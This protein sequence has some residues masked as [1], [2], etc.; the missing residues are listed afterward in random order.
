MFNVITLRLLQKASL[1]GK[2]YNVFLHNKVSH[3]DLGSVVRED[4]LDCSFPLLCPFIYSPSCC[5]GR[6]EA[7]QTPSMASPH[8]HTH[9][10]PPSVN[11]LSSKSVQSGSPGSDWK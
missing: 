1:V 6:W 11:L 8:S 7:Q 3:H 9:K 10:P 4:E 5:S 2:I